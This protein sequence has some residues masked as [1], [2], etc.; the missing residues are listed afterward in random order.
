MP[1]DEQS[2]Y[3]Q[4]TP[5]DLSD[6]TLTRLNS[7][8][9]FLYSQLARTQGITGDFTFRLLRAKSAKSEVTTIPTDEHELLTLGAAQKL[10]NSDVVSVAVKKYVVSTIP[11]SGGGTDDVLDIELTADTPINSPVG[12]PSEGDRL[13][14]IITQDAVGYHQITWDSNFQ[15]ATV[16]IATEPLKNSLFSFIGRSDNKW[17][18]IAAPFLEE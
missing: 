12:P 1:S 13:V 16:E 2:N 10:L 18:P 8:I 6:P 5:R 9:G 4:L 14:V 15:L 3:A 17:W 7:T 11:A